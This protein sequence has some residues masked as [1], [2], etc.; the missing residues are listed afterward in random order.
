VTP[1]GGELVQLPRS[2]QDANGVQRTAKLALD[3]NGTL[4]GDVVE[5]WSGEGAVSRRYLLRA[6]RQD[7]DQI[8]PVETMLSHSLATFQIT[9]AAVANA[10]LNDKPLEWHYTL[11]AERYAKNAGDLLLVRPRVIG[12]ES[13]G[14][15]ETKKPRVHPIEFDAPEHD[16]DAFEIALPPGYV[17]DELPPPVALDLGFASYRSQ[18]EVDGRVLRYSRTLEI[19]D[20]TVP[21]EKAA[22]LKRFYRVIENDERMSA[23]LKRSSP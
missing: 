16:T 5:V 13:S 21:V 14:L 17:V 18:S 22:D 19:R 11:E 1:D 7:V 15:L 23:V 10:K 12:S 2:R 3:E 6:A 20:V 8:K 9:H 4:R